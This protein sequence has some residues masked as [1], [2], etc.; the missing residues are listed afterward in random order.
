MLV[1]YKIQS[2]HFQYLV[3]FGIILSASLIRL[4]LNF[5]S[6]LLPGVNGGY[7]PVQVRSLLESG[8][9]AIEDLPLVFWFEAGLAWFIDLFNSTRH[10][11]IIVAS[12]IIDSILP[13]LTAVPAFY[14]VKHFWNKRLSLAPVL[15]IAF[16]IL[17][18]PS[19][20]LLTGEMHKNAIGLLM[21]ILFLL[22]IAT[23]DSNKKLKSV[24]FT[25]LSLTLCLLT[26]FGSILLVLIFALILFLLSKN[27]KQL[28]IGFFGLGFI[29]V[30]IY[31]LIPG[32]FE[33]ISE[34]L[35][36][37][38]SLFDQPLLF[39]LLKG[40]KVL[41]PALTLML[42]ITHTFAIVTVIIS[43]YYKNVL[44][45]NKFRLAMASSITALIFSTPL[46]GT[47]WALR[48]VMMAHI[49]LILS[50]AVLLPVLSNKS[51]QWLSSFLI[52]TLA[53]S[54]FAAT[55]G[56]RPSSIHPDALSELH[57]MD[58]VLQINDDDLVLAR[59][60]LEWWT[61]WALNCKIAQTHMMETSLFSN[62]RRIYLLNQHYRPNKQYHRGQVQFEE[63]PAPP[64]SEI[65]WQGS[66]FT[67]IYLPD[68]PAGTPDIAEKALAAGKLI[69]TPE[70]EIQITNN[71][72]TNP[73][74]LPTDELK[75]QARQ[76]QQQNI[77]V[78]IY[79]TKKAFSLKIKVKKIK[80]HPST[81]PN[82]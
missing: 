43:S 6:P 61:A 2:R 35:F 72:F 32:R 14:L 62:Y 46:I 9:L 81:I 58:Q 47:E 67:L 51:Q 49:P 69:S 7:Y 13:P 50:W 82:N 15:L 33:R 23:W 63:P 56:N 68:P 76:L 36:S 70:G 18:F 60:G 79:G 37:P 10:S 41:T 4:K 74:I 52:I 59:H 8:H 20:F 22:S 11:G 78:R 42:I 66:Y 65:A 21:V 29:A 1:K 73:L 54:I 80:S 5:S 45:N 16:S 71:T 25:V 28:I 57:E 39:Y 24:S 31:W 26:H 55:T 38:I 75:T 34:L 19:I 3:L 48:L 77:P 64:G 30:L 44:D 53:L 40:Q 17:Y 12:K 27:W